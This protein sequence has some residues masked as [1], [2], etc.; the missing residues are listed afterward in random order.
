MTLTLDATNSD[1]ALLL[2][3]VDSGTNVNANIGAA[4][5]K[6]TSWATWASATYTVCTSANTGNA[7]FIF[8]YNGACASQSSARFKKDVQ[9]E[10]LSSAILDLVPVSF[11]YNWESEADPRRVGVIAEHVANAGLDLLVI[12]DEDQRISGVHYDRMALYLIP[13]VREQR[14]RIAALEQR[15]AAL[16]HRTP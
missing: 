10:P 14:D 5:F 16:E 4:G 12:R 2:S 3:E 6:V 15:L 13:V 8:T 7:G 1:T 9:L 11:L